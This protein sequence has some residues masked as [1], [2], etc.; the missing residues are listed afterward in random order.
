MNFLDKVL[1]LEELYDDL[2]KKVEE[3]NLEVLLMSFETNGEIYEPCIHL[4]E[5]DEWIYVVTFDSE[6]GVDPVYEGI[7]KL[8]SLRKNDVSC[9]GICNGHSFD[10][11]YDTEPDSYSA[12][13]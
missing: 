7:P 10:L 11:K 9:F 2:V 8:L 3:K 6:P 13:R 1:E 5:D 4:T 12:Y